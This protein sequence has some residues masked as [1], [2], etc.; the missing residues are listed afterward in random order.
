MAR[1]SRA[2]PAAL[3]ATLLVV[4][5]GG[6][7]PEPDAGADA[8]TQSS[9]VMAEYS[10]RG[11]PRRLD[12]HAAAIRRANEK[13]RAEHPRT[14]M[15]VASGDVLLH[16]ALW[17]QASA[18]AA[19]SG[20]SGGHD[21]GPMLA[22]IRPV[23]SG[24]DV[25]ICHMETPVAPPGGPFSSYPSFSVPPEIV[26]ALAAT[27]YDA[28]TTASN[29]TYDRGA[30]GITRTLDALDAAGIRHAGSARTP[31]EAGTTTLLDVDGVTV[32][33]LSYTFGF[34]G[35]PAPGGETWRS[36]PIDERRILTDATLARRRGAGVVV[37]ALHWG[38]EYNHDPNGQQ[39]A[40]APRL[41]R[42]PDIDLLLGHHAHVVQPI[43]AI[44][45]EWVVYGMG[46]LVSNQGS[47]GP[48]KLEGLLVRFTFTEQPD[49]RWRVTKA[50]FSVV[51]TDD[52]GPIRVLDVRRAL[53]DPAT[54]PN[55]R[56]RL[57]T[58]WGRTASIAGAR[59]APAHG[60]R[61][62]AP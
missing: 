27:G 33:L 29:H 37:V 39:L 15:L 57:Q 47:Q 36:N 3:T 7:R 52:R 14:F 59:G 51:L 42:S 43:E 32:A 5:L 46:N 25:A 24:A 41:I 31:Q 21:F 19:A 1:R 22:G 55:L 45:D 6:V 9:P 60:L 10:A 62:I 54:D 38:D 12:G 61:P 28:C 17:D 34:N 50:E 16:T 11:E 44:G 53:A 4:A 49:G 13:Y 35:I 2:L 40:L 20:N 23:V 8:T 56:A 26:P 48:D 58:A 30:D 18:D